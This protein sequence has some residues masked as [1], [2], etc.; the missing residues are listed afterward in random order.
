MTNVQKRDVNFDNLYFNRACYDRTTLKDR[1]TKTLCI[2][3]YLFLSIVRRIV[4]MGHF[5]LKKN[6]LDIYLVNL[7][8]DMYY[9]I[10]I[11]TILTYNYILNKNILGKNVS[12][13]AG[14]KAQ[15]YSF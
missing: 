1:K 3:T 7:P 11:I 8:I 10:N 2:C 4:F 6:Y 13:R 5:Y 15:L 12:D 9:S 14:A